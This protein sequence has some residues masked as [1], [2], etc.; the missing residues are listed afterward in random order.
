MATKGDQPWEAATTLSRSS[1]LH[2]HPAIGD[3][4]ECRAGRAHT[5]LVAFSNGGVSIATSW[6]QYAEVWSSP[7]AELVC[8]CEL[9]SCRPVSCRSAS[10]W[11][12]ARHSTEYCSIRIIVRLC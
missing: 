4:V 8:D 2:V 10:R 7:L 9:C 3:A 11:A 6:N 5:C 12:A 1:P